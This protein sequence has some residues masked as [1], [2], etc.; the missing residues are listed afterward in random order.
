M[1]DLDQSQFDSLVKV[2][3]LSSSARDVRCLLAPIN[4]REVFDHLEEF[5]LPKVLHLNFEGPGGTRVM[6]RVQR[7]LLSR[8]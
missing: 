3:S 1:D 6:E 4:L 8:I 2:L 7:C 5:V